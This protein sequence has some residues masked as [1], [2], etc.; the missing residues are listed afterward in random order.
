MH[1]TMRTKCKLWVMTSWTVDTRPQRR[2]NL[3]NFAQQQTADDRLSTHN[4]LHRS[5]L[6]RLFRHK[7]W[8]GMQNAFQFV[9]C[10]WCLS[11]VFVRQQRIWIRDP[12]TIEY[13]QCGYWSMINPLR[14]CILAMCVCRH[15]FVENLCLRYVKE[16]CYASN[17]V[18]RPAQQV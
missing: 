18:M 4:L 13:L 16:E 14:N 9:G 8:F 7:H 1:Q 17:L 12:E 5:A 15:C 10:R 2:L 6:V 3:S 11:I